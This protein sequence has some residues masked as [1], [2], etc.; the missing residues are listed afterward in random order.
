MRKEYIWSYEHT[1]ENLKDLNEY[2]WHIENKWKSIISD[3]ENIYSY[4]NLDN[5]SDRLKFNIHMDKMIHNKRIY[6]WSFD[7][8]KNLV[9]E[10]EPRYYGKNVIFKK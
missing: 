6:N 3:I 1:P 5:D 8:D 7:T 10:P 4:L 9:V 2:F